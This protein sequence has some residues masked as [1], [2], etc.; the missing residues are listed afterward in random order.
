MSAKINMYMYVGG[1]L[2]AHTNIYKYRYILLLEKN[3]LI[4]LMSGEI[5]LRADYMEFLV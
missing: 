3:Y 2:Y 1:C 5:L 4:L